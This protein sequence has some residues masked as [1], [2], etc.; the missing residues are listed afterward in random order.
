MPAQQDQR[1]QMRRALIGMI[2]P[3]FFVTAFTVC[4]VSAFGSPAPHGV[5]VAIAGPG[6]PDRAVARRAEPGRG[7]GL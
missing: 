6:G 7:H 1:S 5:N 4:F 3:L 2:A